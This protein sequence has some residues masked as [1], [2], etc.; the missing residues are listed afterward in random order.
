MGENYNVCWVRDWSNAEGVLDL[1][2]IAN[3]KSRMK[4]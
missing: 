1:G 4:R 3:P 2:F